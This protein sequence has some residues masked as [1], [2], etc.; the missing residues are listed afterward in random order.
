M[1]HG[2]TSALNKLRSIPTSFQKDVLNERIAVMIC[3]FVWAKVN[4][5]AA[6]AADVLW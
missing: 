3:D 6:A 2:A 1:L 4:T 5:A